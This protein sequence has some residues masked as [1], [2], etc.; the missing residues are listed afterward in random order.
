MTQQAVTQSKKNP[1]AFEI[2]NRPVLA[3]LSHQLLVKVSA[4][5]LNQCD[6][7]MPLR[8]PRPGAV[9]GGDYSGIVVRVGKDVT[10]WKVGDRAAGA[11]VASDVGRPGAGSFTEYVV[12][13]ADQCWH[14][15]EHLT[16]EEGAAAGCA[17]TTSVGMALWRSLN[18]SGTP[19]E[20]TPKPKY[21]SFP[22]DSHATSNFLSVE[23]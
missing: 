11:Q 16:W 8:V 20:P 5:A 22:S 6:W 3:P 17:V 13:D 4:V 19:E 21:V 2:T 12:E 15:P 10:G 18:L 7:K 23:R 9:D 14:I 1:G